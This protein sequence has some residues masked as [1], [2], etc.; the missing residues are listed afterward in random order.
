ML[1]MP[2]G[3]YERI[4]HPIM[5]NYIKDKKYLRRNAAIAL[6]NTRDPEYVPM[7]A[8]AMEDP[9]EIVREYSAWALGKIGGPRSKSILEASLRKENSDAVVNE[10]RAALASAGG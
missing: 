2:D 4:I 9:E 8:R 7:L 6:G 1:E 10:I 3:Y 5:Y